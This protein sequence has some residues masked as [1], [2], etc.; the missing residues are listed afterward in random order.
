MTRAHPILAALALSTVATTMSLVANAHVALAGSQTDIVGP[1]GSGQFGRR[2]L[3]LSN[4]NFV[5][6]DPEF[7]KGAVVDVG[8]VYLYNGAT[9]QL[10]STL[11]GSTAGDRVGE[12]SINEVGDS[13][14]VAVSTKWTNAIGAPIA[15][16]GAVTWVSGTTGLNGVVTPANSLVGTTAQDQLGTSFAV[17]SNGNFAV[18]SPSF[19]SAGQ[20]NAGAVTWGSGSGPTVGTL[21]AANSL[22]GTTAGDSPTA[23]KALPT[24]AITFD[25]AARPRTLSTCR[26][27]FLCWKRPDFELI[28]STILP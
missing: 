28:S 22:V 9:R 18:G 3:V 5:V 10:I 4:G 26:P 7:D 11:T 27:P 24:G 2:T 1:A 17:L 14:F 19:R 8:A 12:R 15:E 25:T 23:T 6:T 20:A 16:V 13:N 21:S